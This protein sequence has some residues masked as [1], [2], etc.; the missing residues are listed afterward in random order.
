MG[1]W[2]GHEGHPGYRSLVPWGLCSFLVALKAAWSLLLIFHTC[3]RSRWSSP[4][5]PAALPLV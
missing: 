3:L 2:W 5:I 4:G 1:K